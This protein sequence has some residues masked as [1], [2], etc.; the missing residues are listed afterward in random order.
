M[1]D[2]ELSTPYTVLQPLA[3][4]G[5]GAV[6]IAARRRAG[7]RRLFALKRLRDDLASDPSARAMLLEEGRLAGLIQHP[8]VVPVIDVGE[9]E[10]GVFLV[11]ELV[12]GIS[13]ND[14]LRWAHQRGLPLDLQLVL[15]LVR[16]ACRG[17]HAAHELRVDG[18]PLGLI[19]RDISPQN[20]LIG[21]DGVARVT[22]F[23]IAKA[24]DRVGETTAGLLKGK[25]GYLSPEQLRFEPLDRRADLF[26]L[27]VVL[28]ESLAGDRL[29]RGKEI[30]TVARRILTEPPPDVADHRTDVPPTVVEL[31]FELLAKHPEDR[32][33]TAKDVE[34][35]LEREIA[36]L[37]ATD[38]PFDVQSFLEREFAEKLRETA[39]WA[40]LAE[41]AEMAS[42]EAPRGPT[43]AVVGHAATMAVATPDVRAASEADSPTAPTLHTNPHVRQLASLALVVMLGV[44]V[45]VGWNALRPQN[46]REAPTRVER[47]SPTHPSSE[48]LGTGRS[49]TSGSSSTSADSDATSATSSDSG[50]VPLHPDL[51]APNHLGTTATPNA[52]VE[53]SMAEAEEAIPVQSPRTNSPPSRRMVR[54]RTTRRPRDPAVSDA[55]PPRTADRPWS[56]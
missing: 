2:S 49:D 47:S 29:Y 20:I 30:A 40:T 19:H 50:S 1:Q 41:H 28:F 46:A 31:I 48:E 35:R 39:R 53:D 9:D 54:D 43:L 26:A 18:S 25:V 52:I 45:W 5:M 3:R 16:D 55:P 6:Y 22:D 38:G 23:G 13:L 12:A 36:T 56:W 8:N 15:R 21:F 33:A 51:A 34:Q 14:L 37:A 10:Q 11:M 42:F 32:P 27:G 17:L 24:L 44:L 7:F 4:G